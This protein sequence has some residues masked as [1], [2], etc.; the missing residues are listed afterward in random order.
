[1]TPPRRPPSALPERLRRE[2]HELHRSAER[3]QFMAALLRGR[4]GKPSYNALLRNLHAIYSA[5]EPALERHRQHPW[6]APIFLPAL[7]RSAALADDLAALHGPSWADALELL[8]AGARYGERVRHLDAEQP[9]LLLAHAYVRCLGDLSGGQLLRRVVAD[10]LQLT[11][12]AGTAFYDFGTPSETLALSR[13][14]RSGLDEVIADTA[15]ADALVAEAVLAF[16]LHRSLFD[17]LAEAGNLAGD[18]QP[19]LARG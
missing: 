17:E 19:A 10:T 1:M 4:V 8:P 15:A 11:G 2:T 6:I 16:E 7:W 18:S 13:A 9:G 12:G 3:S 5:L 14:F